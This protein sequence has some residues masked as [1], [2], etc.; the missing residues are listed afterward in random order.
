[1]VNHFDNKYE[2]I[3]CEDFLEDSVLK[4]SEVGVYG[5]TEWKHVELFPFLI[6]NVD[7]KISNPLSSYDDNVSV[8]TYMCV[9]KKYMS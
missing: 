1:M 7:V 6:C 4:V 2:S 3:S 9:N 5:G 8:Y